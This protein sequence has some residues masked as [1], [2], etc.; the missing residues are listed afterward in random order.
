MK[1]ASLR[2][3]RD[4]HV[5]FQGR[6]YFSKIRFASLRK[7]TGRIANMA[8]GKACGTCNITLRPYHHATVSSYFFL[9]YFVLEQNS[10]ER[11]APCSFS[12]VLAEAHLSRAP[13]SACP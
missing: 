5:D 9:M 4:E 8:A 12:F 11:Y 3:Q 13:L 7:N 10:I 2:L 6:E 1:R